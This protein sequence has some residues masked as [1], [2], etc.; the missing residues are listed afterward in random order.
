ELKAKNNFKKFKFVSNNSGKGS[1]KSNVKV[2]TIILEKFDI[3]SSSNKKNNINNSDNLA[4]ITN[5]NEKKEKDKSSQLRVIDYFDTPNP[6]SSVIKPNLIDTTLNAFILSSFSIPTLKL[7]PQNSQKLMNL[8]N[9]WERSIMTRLLS[10]RLNLTLKYPSEDTSACMNTDSNSNGSEELDFLK[11]FDELDINQTE[12][13]QNTMEF[14][15]N[16]TQLEEHL[17]N[18]FF[19]YFN[20]VKAIV[21]KENFYYKLRTQWN[22]IHFQALLSTMLCSATPYLSVDPYPYNNI[23]IS[24][25]GQFYYNRG[26]NLYNLI[27]DKVSNNSINIQILKLTSYLNYNQ[28]G[29]NYS[30]IHIL[31]RELQWDKLFDKTISEIKETRPKYSYEEL[32]EWEENLLILSS[33]FFHSSSLM[34][35]G[36]YTIS[37]V[38]INKALPNLEPVLEALFDASTS[39]N[40]LKTKELQLTYLLYKSQP[41]LESAR[42]YNLNNST[43]SPTSKYPS[44]SQMEKLYKIQYQ[45]NLWKDKITTYIFDNNFKS[46]E[47]ALTTILYIYYHYGQLILIIPHLPKTIEEF[48]T[49]FYFNLFLEFLKSS[50]SLLLLMNCQGTWMTIFASGVKN[51][52]LSLSYTGIKLFKHYLTISKFKNSEISEL[53]QVIGYN[54]LKTVTQSFNFSFQKNLSFRLASRRSD[55]YWQKIRKEDNSL[56]IS[57]VRGPPKLSNYSKLNILN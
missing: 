18:L 46:K 32:I 33:T 29:E 7:T 57:I 6:Y 38:D 35:S 13:S 39:S 25:L 23:N 53:L 20:L 52:I 24:K 17:I 37:G 42:L 50:N 22:T 28:F 44:L 4:L 21:H 41:I 56:N 3:S 45:L 14:S 43:R 30:K 10:N 49:P 16:L 12:L 31:I 2:G 15:P 51:F 1:D 5:Y 48:D 8:I 40:W 54:L 36:S 55:I 19:N 47:L 27:E 34:V 9:P 11:S 26:I